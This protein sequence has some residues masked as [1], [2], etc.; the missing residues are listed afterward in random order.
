MQRFLVIINC[1]ILFSTEPKDRR[2]VLKAQK[3]HDSKRKRE[4]GQVLFPNFLWR[5]LVRRRALSRT[6]NCQFGHWNHRSWSK[7]ARLHPTCLGASILVNHKPP[8][9]YNS[10]LS[11]DRELRN[12]QTSEIKG[13]VPDLSMEEVE[14]ISQANR[15]KSLSSGRV[16]GWSVSP[17]TIPC[18]S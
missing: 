18:A 6:K 11:L 2:W 3:M 9:I 14:P 5:L 10:S 4:K 1:K 16:S 8:S 7:N 12:L 17:V 13:V 15:K